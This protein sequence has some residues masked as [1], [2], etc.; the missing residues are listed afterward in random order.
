MDARLS[1]AEPIELRTD[2]PALPLALA[3][4]NVAPHICESAQE[5]HERLREVQKQS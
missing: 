3:Q 2:L 1:R 5:A 4:R